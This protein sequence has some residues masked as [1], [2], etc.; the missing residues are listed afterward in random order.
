MTIGKGSAWPEAWEDRLTPAG[1]PASAIS[2][3]RLGWWICRNTNVGD[4]KPSSSTSNY[5][6]EAL[7]KNILTN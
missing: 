4:S 1:S 2:Q 5:S 3:E 6:L 7:T